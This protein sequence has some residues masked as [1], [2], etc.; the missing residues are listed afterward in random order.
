M[1]KTEERL[2][3]SVVIGMPSLDKANAKLEN[4]PIQNAYHVFACTTQGQ[5]HPAMQ[6]ITSFQQ[7]L[8]Q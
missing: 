5:Q 3:R 8:S 2:C 7:A 6:I 1:Y 4:K